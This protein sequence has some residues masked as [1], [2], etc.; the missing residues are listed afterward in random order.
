MARWSVLCV[1]LLLVV[2]NTELGAAEAKSADWPQF[3]GPNRD[4]ISPDKGLLRQWPK[5]GPRLLWK[6]KSIG[7]GYSSVA[8]AGG[9]IFTLGNDKGK[10]FVYAISQEDGKA[11]W[12]AELGKAG[13]NLG[14]TP[15]VDGDMVYVIGQEGDLACIR[16][17][18]GEIVWR[19]SFFEDFE[20]KYGGWKFT[21]SPLIDGDQLVCTPGGKDAGMVALNKKTG[22]VVWKC[23][24][25][26]KNT[27]AGY[28]SIVIANVGGVR[29][30]VQ[31]MAA[32]VVGVRAKDGKFLWKYQNM[33]DGNTANIPT[34]IVIG[35]HLFCAAGYGKGA[36]LLQIVVDKDDVS[37]KEIYFKRELTNKHG[38]VVMVGDYVYGDTDD[39]G[40]PYCAE[41]KTGKVMWKKTERG[42]GEKSA[43]VT[44][45][46]GHLYFRYQN[47]V[48]ALVEATPKEYKEV[49][50]FKIPDA[51]GPSWAHPVVVGGKMYLREGDQVLCFDVRDSQ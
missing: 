50:S 10:T 45:A 47:G 30:Y 20:G 11:L 36:A 17:A 27:A 25:P 39:S 44:Y 16:A 43:A 1:W 12:Q 38:G 31:L 35:D 2:A 22:L 34:P 37:V 33:F 32:G 4:D 7:S 49:S 51:R 41:V 18:S 14:C 29:Q 28:S 6:A 3:R 24:I 9:K 19:K 15:T 40:Y 5:D 8:I 26:V 46:D 21:E 13:G 42:P 48:M 23:P